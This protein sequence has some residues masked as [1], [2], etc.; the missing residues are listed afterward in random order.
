MNFRTTIKIARRALVANRA[1]MILTILGMVIGIAAVIVVFSAG[2]GIRLLVLDQVK[3]FG[4]DIIQTEVKVPTGKKGGASEQQSA[5]AITQGVQVTTLTLDDMAAV[6]ALPNVRQSYAGILS[7]EP[8]AYGSELRRTLLY[9]VSATYV[10]IDHT[11]VAQGR[12]FNDAEDR[13]LAQ[14]A[15]LGPKIAEK[16]F[17]QNDPLDNYI[18]I[19]RSK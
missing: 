8:V 7:Q 14:V 19:G 10:E 1:R 13:S 3:S 18:R 16:L 17:G 12:F 2:M 4:T 5:S 15:V 9:G 6:D 11:G